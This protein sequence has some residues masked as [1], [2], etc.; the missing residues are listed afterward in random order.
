MGGLWRA[1][2]EMRQCL[3]ETRDVFNGVV[4]GKPGKWR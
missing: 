4:V 3:V 2:G 1:D